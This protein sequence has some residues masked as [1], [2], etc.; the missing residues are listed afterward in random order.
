MSDDETTDTT[1]ADQSSESRRPSAPDRAAPPEP[2]PFDDEDWTPTDEPP[3]A[4]TAQL[5]RAATWL[6]GVADGDPILGDRSR[7]DPVDLAPGV[8]E[9]VAL[10][11]GERGVLEWAAWLGGLGRPAHAGVLAATLLVHTRCEPIAPFLDHAESY[12]VLVEELVA[13]DRL[14]PT[15]WLWHLRATASEKLRPASEE[16]W[17]PTTGPEDEQQQ[18]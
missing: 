5:A 9:V 1:G 18:Q 12:L 17:S 4:T 13:R 10:L 14:L 11:L 6:L 8:V 3:L 15:D 16:V 7:L 2:G